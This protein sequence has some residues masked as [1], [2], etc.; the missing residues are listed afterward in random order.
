LVWR[1]FAGG[2]L[3]TWTLLYGLTAC[4]FVLIHLTLFL[5]HGFG[6]MHESTHATF[7]VAAGA[8]VPAVLLMSASVACLTGRGWPRVLAAIGALSHVGWTGIAIY[9]L[10]E[11]FVLVSTASYGAAACGLS[12]LFTIVWVIVLLAGGKWIG[13]SEPGKPARAVPYPLW[14]GPLLIV[15][16]ALSIVREVIQ[17]VRVGVEMAD[18]TRLARAVEEVHGSYPLFFAGATGLLVS[19]LLVVAGIGLLR[20]KRWTVGLGGVAGLLMLL[21][22]G[23]A[24]LVLYVWD[25]ISNHGGPL[26]GLVDVFILLACGI[27]AWFALAGA[28]RFGFQLP[29]YLRETAEKNADGTRQKLLSVLVPTTPPQAP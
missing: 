7:G 5:K 17:L 14:A 9:V 13:K 28:L 20:R 29:R 3:L 1:T 24:I 21:V 2:A 12:G 18:S 4:V 25:D 8:L 16:G 19:V 15:L 6:L 27:G 26:L 10:A 22:D 23:T 11:N